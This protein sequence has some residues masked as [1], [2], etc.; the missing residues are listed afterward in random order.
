MEKILEED[1]FNARALTWEQLGYEAGLDISGKTI[2]RYMGTMGYHKCLACRKRCCNEK[3]KIKRVEV[4]D[5]WKER[6][7]E[8]EGW[9]SVRFSNEC[10]YGF[11]PQDTPRIIR[12]P[13]EQHCQDC[14][15]EGDPKGDGT[16]KGEQKRQHTWASAGHDF[17]SDLTYYDSGISN[18]K[19]THKCYRE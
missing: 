11:G 12:K 4:C 2:K 17:K 9:F 3:T 16:K 14:I 1:A 15:Q 10:H 8:K 19:M 6:C 5:I 13:G 7:P 18:G